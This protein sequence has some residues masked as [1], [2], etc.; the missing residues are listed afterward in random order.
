[1]GE[2]IGKSVTALNDWIKSAKVLE[3]T[4]ALLETSVVD[5]KGAGR[6]VD[7][8]TKDQTRA[9]LLGAISAPAR[10]LVQIINAP[11]A[12]LAR[13]STRM[14]TEGSGVGKWRPD[15]AKSCRQPVV[16]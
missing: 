7:L 14:P 8:P 13:V 12:S 4:G 1:M 3:V 10:T 2:D 9:M 5:A 11:G 15:R 6:V 16:A